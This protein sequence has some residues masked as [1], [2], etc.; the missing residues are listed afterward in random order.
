MFLASGQDAT[1][2]QSFGVADYSVVKKI[3]GSD[4]SN[5]I[6]KLNFAKK[7]GSEID[8][9]ELYPSRPYGPESVLAY[10]E[11]I[12]GIFGTQQQSGYFEQLGFIVWKPPR[13]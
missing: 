9:V 13:I 8:K 2:L 11:E 12:I 1:N 3:K 7:D 6:Q 4:T 10:D 5:Q